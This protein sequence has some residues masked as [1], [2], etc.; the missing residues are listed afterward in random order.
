M[1]RNRTKTLNFAVLATYAVFSFCGSAFHQWSH[2]G[3]GPLCSA[4]HVHSQG[5][6]HGCDEVSDPPHRHLCGSH[7]D[8][9]S[10]C[11]AHH[12]SE[13]RRT[14]RSDSKENDSD[15]SELDGSEISQ[16]K[17]NP[18]C[19]ANPHYCCE[20]CSMLSLLSQSWGSMI[21]EVASETHFTNV[22]FET[23]SFARGVDAWMARSRAPPLYAI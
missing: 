20:I 19:K 23:P 22:L 2:H 15:G 6:E 21:S 14:Q 12:A 18:H 5:P 4:C 16:A 17:A 10:C 11:H 7:S 13:S 9:E 8:S 3:S 1:V